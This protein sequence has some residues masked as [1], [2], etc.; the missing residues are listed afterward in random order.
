[1]LVSQNRK[2]INNDDNFWRVATAIDAGSPETDFPFAELV[3][4][5]LIHVLF[6]DPS[7]GSLSLCLCVSCILAVLPAGDPALYLQSRTH[8]LTLISSGVGRRQ[9]ER[10]RLQPQDK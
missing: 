2:N 6:T 9:R 5:M 4:Y 8:E 1:M 3:S 10:N 7:K